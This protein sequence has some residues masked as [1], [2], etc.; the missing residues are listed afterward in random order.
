MGYT[1]VIE[2]GAAQPSTTQGAR[3]CAKEGRAHPR[4]V[5]QEATV[6]VHDAVDAC[7]EAETLAVARWAWW[8]PRQCGR[9][10]AVLHQ[11]SDAEEGQRTND[12]AQGTE[13]QP[14]SAPSINK[15]QA[16]DGEGEVE[17][18]DQRYQPY[19]GARLEARRA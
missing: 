4:S 6:T 17:E 12:T 16:D 11:E 2:C 5:S 1:F 7:G 15:V 13:C 10:R 8:A 14:P 19:G 3:T 18:G 9:R